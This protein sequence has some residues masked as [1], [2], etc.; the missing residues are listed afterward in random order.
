M[1]SISD[2]E[3]EDKDIVIFVI[4]A[5]AGG[6]AAIDAV[7]SK[8][9]YRTVIYAFEAREFG[10]HDKKAYQH[11]LNMGVRVVIINRAV[12]GKSGLQKFYLNKQTPSSSLLPPSEKTINDHI[13]PFTTDQKITTWGE[14]T[15]LDKEVE[16]DAITLK[17]FIEKEGVTP[18][19]IVADVQGMELEVI[20]GMGDYIKDV[21]A[22]FTEVE[23]YEIYK[24]QA[25][26]S[27]QSQYYEVNNI[28]LAE[29]Y[30]L[31]RWHP[32]PAAGSG[33][34]TVAEALWMRTVDSMFEGYKG[35]GK[36][37]MQLIKQIK[38]AAIAFCYDKLSYTYA[39]LERLCVE[40]GDTEIV[41]NSVR[42]MC[43][44]LGYNRLVKLHHHI[45]A[46]LNNYKENNKF[47]L[48]NTGEALQIRDGGKAIR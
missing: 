2:F 35:T 42:D 40:W 32:A 36:Q 30:G 33:F 18:D 10:D 34:L 4:G 23:F 31:Q 13:V 45:N 17:E 27:D 29:M 12:S 8:F 46:N 14:N 9:P 44:S 41:R 6:S 16:L 5:G 11:Y 24:G 38:Q 7:V 20:K 25:L 28:R 15:E 26:F 43:D 3:V 19:L 1:N 21:G 47:F 48:D 37:N 39:V 22:L